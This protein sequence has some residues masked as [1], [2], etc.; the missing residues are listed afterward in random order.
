[1][2]AFWLNSDSERLAAA[3]LADARPAWIWSADSE[4]LIWHNRAAT[5]YEASH[6]RDPNTRLVPVAR[7]IPRAIRLGVPLRSSRARLQFTLGRKPVSET[8]TCTPLTLDGGLMALL[9]VMADAVPAADLQAVPVDNDSIQPFAG[10]AVHFVLTGADG[11]VLASGGDGS[12]RLEAGQSPLSELPAG[13]GG[14]RLVIFS[15]AVPEPADETIPA[16]ADTEADNTPPEE[17]EDEADNAAP[18]ADEQ[19]DSDETAQ[20]HDDSEPAEIA[21]VETTEAH[22]DGDKLSVLLDQLDSRQV[23]YQPL[24]DSDDDFLFAPSQETSHPE[25]EESGPYLAVAQMAGEPS[26]PALPIAAA[27][28]DADASDTDKIDAAPEDVVFEGEAPAPTDTQVDDDTEVVGREARDPIPVR[29]WKVIGRGFSPRGNRSEPSQDAETDSVETALTDTSDAS[30]DTAPL[31]EQTD[32]V[33]ASGDDADTSEVD[34]QDTAQDDD[35]A[36]ISAADEAASDDDIERETRYNFDELSRILIDRVSSDGDAEEVPDEPSVAAPVSSLVNLG[37]EHLI[38]NRL[39][40]GLLVFRDQEI[41]FSNRALSDLLGYVDGSSL[42]QAGL[43]GVFPSDGEQAS[44]GPVTKLV[45]ADGR[46]VNVSARLQTVIWQGRTALLLSASRQKEPLNAEDLARSFAE[47][48]GNALECG[49]F[50]TSRAGMLTSVS[51]RAA[52][53]AGRTPDALIGR[54]LHSLIAVNQAAR[55]RGFLERPARSAGVERP[56]I[57]L[58]G[59]DAD[60]EVIVFAEGMAGIVTGYFGLLRRTE[61]PAGD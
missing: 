39:P 34:T 26:E 52:T 5:A 7:Q 59:A 40:I 33:M 55:L 36:P 60:T 23:L 42:R 43:A 11:A 2:T 35:D 44:A 20:A 29:L 45:G 57:R 21:D 61:Q 46:A 18:H 38:L 30:D 13:D 27:G 37:D 32:L 8:C 58:A 51:G 48:M 15:D 31:A 6:R 22:A 10:E 14:S 28:E 25:I 53:L 4:K 56:M 9:V 47:L 1:M 50:E 19:P 3:H 54:S 17:S 12:E 16:P 41:L 49:Y 24:S